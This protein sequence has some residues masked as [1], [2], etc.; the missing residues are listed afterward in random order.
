MSIPMNEDEIIVVDHV[1]QDVYLTFVQGAVRYAVLSLPFTVNRM[2]I[3]EIERRVFNIAKGKLAERLFEWYCHQVGLEVDFRS[4]QT[5]FWAVDRRDFLFRGYEWDLKNNFL[6]YSGEK[7]NRYTQ[8]PALVPN[9]HDHDQWSSRLETKFPH[10][11]GV[12]FLF[13]FMKGADVLPNGQ[14]RYFLELHFSEEQ[15]R[16]LQKLVDKYQGHPADHPPFDGE[17]CWQ[18]WKRLNPT[19]IQLNFR[20]ALV[21]TGYADREQWHLFRNVGPG[22]TDSDSSKWFVP[23]GA[24]GSLSWLN[25]VLWTT[26]DNMVAPIDQLKS[27]HSLVSR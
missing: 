14:R 3:R 15:L 21:I 11:R 17:K 12:N 8:L 20:P 4:C 27:F 1:P 19:V 6:Y 22:D 18:R 9:R 13:T 10:S 24:R 2:D 5:P 23:V 7:F 25:G 26:I 16:F